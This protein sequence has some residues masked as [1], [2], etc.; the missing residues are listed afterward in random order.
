MPSSAVRRFDDPDEY[1]AAMRALRTELTVT[2]RGQFA[3]DLTR[4]DLHN[5]WMQ[6]FDDNLPRIRQSV[7]EAERVIISF[8]TRPG[9]ELLWNGLEILPS[10]LIRHAV[11][12]ETY[13]RSAGHAAWGSMSL[14]ADKADCL[15]AA[16]CGDEPGLQHETTSFKSSPDRITKLRRLHAA[17]GLLAQDAPGVIAAPETARGLEQALIGALAA[18]LSSAPSAQD[19]A[20]RSR[21]EAVMRRF[22][23]AVEQ[24]P[25]D[26]VYIPELCVAI[27]VPQRT[28]HMC[29]VE[30]LGISPKRYLLLRRMNLARKTLR[31]ADPAATTVTQIATQFGFWNFGRFSVEYRSLFSEMPSAT[32]RT[33][34]SH[35]G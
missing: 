10:S 1:A 12:R 35:R 32:L 25:E 17:A 14:P 27:A 13:Q 23:E 19:M 24:H 7:P 16:L 2:A 33:H 34:R 31:I 6:R 28:L 26:A 4:V 3:A 21:H 8:R 29:C 22:H 5:L 15:N 18:C 30:S 20:A 9:P 11:G